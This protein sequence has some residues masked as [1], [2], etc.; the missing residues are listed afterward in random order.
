MKQKKYTYFKVT[1]SDETRLQSEITDSQWHETKNNILAKSDHWYPMEYGIAY[2]QI[3]RSTGDTLFADSYRWFASEQA[4]DE[5]FD[6][7][8]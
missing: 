1:W 4:R 3:D 6:R 2:C 7:I 5:E 8:R